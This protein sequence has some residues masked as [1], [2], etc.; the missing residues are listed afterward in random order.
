MLTRFA[1]VSSQQSKSGA[2]AACAMSKLIAEQ[3]LVLSVTKPHKP[4]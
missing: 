3:R 1:L 2:E 4:T